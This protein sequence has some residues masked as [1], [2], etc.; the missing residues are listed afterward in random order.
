MDEVWEKSQTVDPEVRAYVYSLVNAVGGSS[1]YDDTYQVGDDAY[2]ALQDI[3]RWLRLY[4][5]K[6]N[7]FDV[8]RCLAEA[9]LVKGDLLEILALWP[10]E[11]QT[12]TLKSKLALACLQLL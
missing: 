11:A 6:L 10:E 1:T 3:L 9:N 5:E 4:D 2:A 8:K 7:R 12:Q